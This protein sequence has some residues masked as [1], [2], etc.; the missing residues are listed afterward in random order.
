[1]S[2]SMPHLVPLRPKGFPRPPASPII[3]DA[4]PSPSEPETLGRYRVVELLGAGANGLV[5]RAFDPEADAH[6]ALKVLRPDAGPGQARAA[7]LK[8]EFRLVSDLTHRN[9]VL[10]YTLDQ[11]G[12]RVFFTMELVAGEPIVAWLQGRDEPTIRDAFAQLAEG[13]LALHDRGLLHRDIKP[14]N[15]LVEAGGRVAILDFGLVGHVDRPLDAGRRYFAGSPGYL[16]PEIFGGTPASPASDAYAVGVIL[17]EILTG[18]WPYHADVRE[19]V[20]LRMLADDAPAIS[21]GPPDLAAI[22][23]GLLHVDPERRASLEQLLPASTTRSRPS[24]RATT[25]TVVG[26]EDELARLREAWARMRQGERPL[27]VHV[28]GASGMGKSALLH[29]FGRELDGAAWVLAGRAYE[30]DTVPFK[31][32]DAAMDQLARRIEALPPA[33]RAELALT[34][35][36]GLAALFPALA[37]ALGVTTERDV[38]ALDPHVR[39]RSGVRALGDLLTRVADRHGLVL[40]LDDLQWGDLDSARLL[41]DLLTAPSPRMLVL[42]SYRAQATGPFLELVDRWT[43]TE[44]VTETLPVE[45]LSHASALR[46]AQSI[47]GD[48]ARALEVA[49][50]SEGCPFLI[51][52]LASAPRDTAL[53]FEAAL[54]QRLSTLADPAR[55]MLEAVCLA[56][57]PVE[58]D[59]VPFAPPRATDARAAWAALVSERLLRS[60]AADARGAVEPYHDRIRDAV[61]RGMADDARRA[62]HLA[63][64]EAF[65]S[66]RDDE[67]AAVHLAAGGDRARA[68]GYA[69]AAAQ[70][71]IAALAFDRAAQLFALAVECCDADPARRSA[72]T[73]RRARALADAGRGAEAAPLF[74]EGAR[75]GAQL[76]A[77]DLRRQAMEQYLVVGR[78]DEGRAL[79]RSLLDD[80]GVRVPRHQALV[81][82]AL[83]AEVARLLLRGAKLKKERIV[84]GRDRLVLDTF[85]S[86][87]KGLM[88]CDASLGSWFFLRAARRALDWGEAQLAARGITYLASILGFSGAPSAVARAERWLD[89]AEA[90]ARGSDDEHALAFCLVGRGM[91]SCC[92]GRW[93]RAIEDFDRAASALDARFGGSDW[94]SNL[95]K[96]TSLFALVQMGDVRE[97]EARAGALT[98]EA[99]ERGDLALEVESNLYLAFTALARDNVADARRCIARNL[100]LWT[101]RGYHFQHWIALRFEALMLL[102]AGSYEEALAR[103]E[104][105][106][107]LARAANLTSMQVVRVE[108]HDLRGRAAVGVALRSTGAKRER[109]LACLREDAEQ[110]ASEG[111]SHARAPAEALRAGLALASGDGAVARSRLLHAALA[112]EESSMGA[113]ALAMRWH[114]ASLSEDRTSREACERALAARGI[115][116]PSRWARMSAPLPER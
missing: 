90:I 104:E 76:E 92:T 116:A 51:E 108:G 59:R 60:H 93:A 11:D 34:D 23:R 109:A 110:L 20:V 12:D 69:E 19:S 94:E 107:S 113:H 75:S 96:G 64:G 74:L 17:H 39:R 22:C 91:V 62:T 67:G 70:S 114:V 29:S 72:L 97:L 27:V 30:R 3:D 68:L 9:L 83:Y 111:R 40:M 98:Q 31:A 87:G 46:F 44:L 58:R 13:L 43:V 55:R 79:M 38:E 112:Y 25:A 8:R 48:D 50:E 5:Y 89:A 7:D 103:M 100:G 102:Y 82:A 36:T 115:A 35:A 10:P 1:M 57:R 77:L 42:L 4:L 105:G 95:A 15:V 24:R 26:R 45:P 80:L 52:M 49:R 41:V 101:V 47:A 6:V 33:Q 65:I 71:A 85:A 88:S 2:R 73:L 78:L 56:G 86:I 32:V 16:A 18:T 21:A 61:T 66:A 37:T 84:T 99:R 53:S 106:L 81:N 28:P 54:A 14:S 63:L